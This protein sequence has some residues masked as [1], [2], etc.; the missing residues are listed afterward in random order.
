MAEEV[1]SGASVQL[2]H[3]SLGAGV[4]AFGAVVVVG[5]CEA[6]IY[7]GPVDFEAV[8]KAAQVGQV[9]GPGGGDPLGKPWPGPANYATR[10]TT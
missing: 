1:E 7:S 10:L 5:Q 4:G 3:D 6:G 2:S 9:H 8:G